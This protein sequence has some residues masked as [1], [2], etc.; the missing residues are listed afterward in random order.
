MN[1]LQPL[2]TAVLLGAVL[3]LGLWSFVATLPR[4]AR[5]RLIDRI[6]AYLVDVAP[7]A[8]EYAAARRIDP[9]PVLGQLLTPPVRWLQRILGE[10]VGGTAATA[11]RLR[12]AASPLSVERFRT[13]QAVWAL[14]GAAIAM[15]VALAVLRR[16]NNELLVLVLL[17]AL[18]AAIGVGLRELVLRREAAARL[19]R[20]ASEYPTVLEFMSLSLAAGVGIFDAMA[21][22]ATLGA[23]E[24]GREFGAVVRR[25]RAGAPLTEALREATE[26]LGYVPLARTCDHLLTALARGAPLVEV[27][28]AQAADAR[29]LEKR[30]LLEKAGRNEIRMMIPLV[31]LILPITVLFALYPS[32]FIMSTAF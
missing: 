26:T 22:V 4:L 29:D 25:V 12:Q 3:G 8:R 30:D 21:R 18:G 20:I 14:V 17:P 31:M 1:P 27:L 28:Q 7:A 6:A 19:R 24:L 11:R 23:S 9:I 15:A 13:E 10:V 2:A 5:P 16:A 32:L